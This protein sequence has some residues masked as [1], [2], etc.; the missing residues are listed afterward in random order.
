MGFL[1]LVEKKG[2]H[3]MLR[4]AYPRGEITN[5]NLGVFSNF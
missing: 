3:G 2:K 5:V 1:T 4:Y